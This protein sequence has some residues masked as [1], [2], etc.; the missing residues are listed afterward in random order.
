MDEKINLL[1]SA[2]KNNYSITG[3]ICHFDP[4][5]MWCEEKRFHRFIIKTLSQRFEAL[6]M[7]YDN[8]YG[9]LTF[10]SL[11]RNSDK[12]IVLLTSAL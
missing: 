9:L 5:E 1:Y 8:I 2:V 4:I 11:K 3:P 7:V 10:F 12:S 6:L